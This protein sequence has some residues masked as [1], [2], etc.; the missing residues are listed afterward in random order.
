MNL[1]SGA[2]KGVGFVVAVAT[3]GGAMKLAFDT[4]QDTMKEFYS[5]QVAQIEVLQKQV[6]SLKN[7]SSELRAKNESLMF[8]LEKIEEDNQLAKGLLEAERERVLELTRE[9][10]ARKARIELNNSFE[11]LETKEYKGVAFSVKDCLKNGSRIDCNVIMRSLE[12]DKIVHV[13]PQT[14]IFDDFGNNARVK[15]YVSSNGKITSPDGYCSIKFSLIEGVNTLYK[16][17]FA[18]PS[19]NTTGVSALKIAL[20]SSCMSPDAIMTFKSISLN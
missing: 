14:E 8:T 18:S 10:A 1:L 17:S 15:S 6:A 19:N 2:N 3:V 12:G 4:G 13:R 16:Y 9:N 11:K 7:E 5:P 20:G